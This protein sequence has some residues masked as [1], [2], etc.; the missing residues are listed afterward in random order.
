MNLPLSWLADFVNVSD[1]HAKDYCDR[2]TD[3]GSKVEG[4]EILGE[5]I[6]NVLVAKL[7]KIVPHPDSDHL[8]ICTVN[9][10]A[11]EPLQIVTGAQNIAEGDIVSAAIPV[12]KLS[13]GV[14]IKKGK[15]R[16]VESNGMLCSMGELGLS[17]H[18]MP[19][20]AADGIL[21]LDPEMES[22]L[23]KDIKEALM[24]TDTV[25]EFEITSNRPDCLSVIGLARES[26]VSFDRPLTLPTPTVKGCGDGDRIENHLSVG[27]E[28]DD[29]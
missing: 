7:E 17:E 15:L 5:D 20:K 18:D 8:Q 13:G 24:L 3:T 21:I 22:M 26:A 6:E 1:I 16:G 11:A 9:I 29:L 25:V 27:I 10:G 28:A 4:Y 2:M 14:V 19:G 23:G 12:A